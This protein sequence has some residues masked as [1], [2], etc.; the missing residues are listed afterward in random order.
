LTF[1]SVFLGLIT[2]PVRPD[3]FVGRR[4][5]NRLIVGARS[6]KECR[7]GGTKNQDPGALFAHHTATIAGGSGR[8]QRSFFG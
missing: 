5:S 6:Q 1:A 7:C 3:H 4:L 8:M 2:R